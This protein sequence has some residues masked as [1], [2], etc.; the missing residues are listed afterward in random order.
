[1]EA[2]LEP[3]DVLV[4]SPYNAQVARLRQALPAGIRA[5]TVDTF[6]GK[7]APVVLYSMATSTPD[8][9]PRE[10][11]FLVSLNRFNVATSRA[12]ALVVVVASPALLTAPC[13][14]PEQMR[15]VNALARY[16]ELADVSEPEIVPPQ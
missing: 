2:P 16:V 1:V 4:V 11:G 13:R 6:Q 7:Q 5:G 3:R 10:M 9:M 15:L 8:D 12:Q 14:T